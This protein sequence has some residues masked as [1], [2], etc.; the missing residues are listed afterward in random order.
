MARTLSN[1]PPPLGPAITQGNV[2]QSLLGNLTQPPSSPTTRLVNTSTVPI[3][4]AAAAAASSS[5][6]L[7]IV[8]VALGAVAVLV[9]AVALVSRRGTPTRSPSRGLLIKPYFVSK[10][11]DST[12]HSL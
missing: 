7:W 2:N 6:S 9:G 5:S 3:S 4:A 1:L 10:T 12:L 11:K 8:L